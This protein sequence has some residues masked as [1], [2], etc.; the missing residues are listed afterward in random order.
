VG[1]AALLFDNFRLRRRG[2]ALE[3]VAIGALTYNGT[4]DPA[5]KV[6]KGGEQGFVPLTLESVTDVNHNTKRFKFKFEDSKAV[7]GLT[8]CCKATA[9]HRHYSDCGSGAID[10]VPKFR[11]GQ[12]NHQGVYP[13]QS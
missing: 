11:F 13:H 3:Q 7:S 9:Y 4:L 1:L 8:Y 6:F 5:E 2:D 10:E 12:A